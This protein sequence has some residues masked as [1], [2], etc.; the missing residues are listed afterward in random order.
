MRFI[1]ILALL[2]LMAYALPNPTQTPQIGAAFACTTHSD[3]AVKNRPNCCGHQ[4]VCAH[5]SAVFSENPNCAGRMSVCGFV[6]IAAC[7]CRNG[8]CAAARP[9]MGSAGGSESPV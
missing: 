2:P 3:C 9:V 5:Q 1:A 6:K 7:E 8:A 4:D